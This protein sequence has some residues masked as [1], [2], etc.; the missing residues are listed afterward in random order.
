MDLA[1]EI[2]N[3]FYSSDKDYE[4]VVNLIVSEINSWG[5]EYLSFYIDESEIA[6]DNVYENRRYS[7]D[8]IYDVVDITYLYDNKN[9]TLWQFDFPCDY[10][11]PTYGTNIKDFMLKY[12]NEFKYTYTTVILGYVDDD[13]DENLID[14]RRKWCNKLYDI[15]KEKFPNLNLN[16]YED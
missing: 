11:P 10:A 15:L 3:L 1:L 6:K 2:K 12:R 13:T 7:K 8:I 4:E 14:D 16:I 5:L 9:I